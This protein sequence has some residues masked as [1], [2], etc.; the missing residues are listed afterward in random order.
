MTTVSLLSGASSSQVGSTFDAGI[1]QTSVSLATAV[2]G[3][4]SFSVQ[5]QS[6]ADGIT[7]TAAGSAVASAG[8]SALTVSARYF[9]ADLTWTSGP[10]SVTVQLGYTPAGGYSGAGSYDP[11]GAAASAA[12]AD[13][14]LAESFSLANGAYKDRFRWNVGGQTVA[15][16]ADF[17]RVAGSQTYTRA[18]YSGIQGPAFWDGYNPDLLSG[19]AASAAHGAIGVSCFGSAGDTNNGSGGYGLEYNIAFRT[20]DGS[21]VANAFQ[22]VATDD[23]T[24]TLGTV[25][26]CGTGNSN[27]VYSSIT[28]QNADSSVT[29]MIMGPVVSDQVYVYRPMSAA[30]DMNALPLPGFTIRN[31][32]TS[33]GSATFQID[34]N[35]SAGLAQLAL[36]NAGINKWVMGYSAAL[37]GDYFIEDAAN[38]RFPVLLQ[39]GGSAAASLMTLDTVVTVKS[40][41]VVSSGAALAAAATDG[42]FYIP[43]SAAAPTGTPAPKAGSIPMTYYGGK[44]WAYDGAWKAVTLS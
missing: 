44:I 18:G 38:G 2:K 21:K 9:R 25:I 17:G 34:V 5:L 15:T 6:S 19:K 22:A 1:P 16:L 8:T 31:T 35:N 41:L 42:Y 3:S 10:G 11:A 43:Q 30:F 33:A 26:R 28:L 4:P 36:A 13:V 39:P 23:N 14:P 24:G 32:N 37:G 12:A 27:G 29:Y 40:S 7:W 20:A